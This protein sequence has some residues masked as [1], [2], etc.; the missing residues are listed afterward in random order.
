MALITSFKS[1][2]FRQ[3]IL[4]FYTLGSLLPLLFLVY[5]LV[6][7]VF[8]TLTQDQMDNLE[9]ILG[10]ALA[11]MLLVPLLGYAMIRW[12]IKS[13]ETLTLDIK[14]LSREV[15]PAEGDV[16]HEN[17]MVAL[18][19]HFEG[20][21]GEL[22]DK[23]Q[24]INEY[25]QKLIEDNIKLSAQ[26]T[27]DQLTG[28]YNRRH[29]DRRLVQESAAAARYGHELSLIMIDA[30]GFKQ[31]NDHFGHPAGDRLLANLGRLI[32]SAVRR[33]DVAFRYGGDEF[34]VILPQCG[35]KNAVNIA[36]KMSRLVTEKQLEDTELLRS[37]PVTISCGVAEFSMNAEQLLG[38]ADKS[39]YAAKSKGRGQVMYARPRTRSE[40]K[41]AADRDGA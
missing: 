21:Y 8:P 26:A 41:P 7:Y 35:I 39:L 18:R 33:A 4:S 14:S 12:W 20:L 31:F 19:Q 15:M 36:R 37:S 3:A 30:D 16:R 25:S 24:Q 1:T 5:V 32:R 38:D 10:L 6:D 13:I 17:E 2:R 22:Q 34:A 40:A 11:V 28:L 29:F 9:S 23:V 27:I